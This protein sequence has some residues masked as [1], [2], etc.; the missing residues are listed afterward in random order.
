MNK[1]KAGI[2]GATGYAGLEIARLLLSHPSVE[3]AAV[4]SVSF[5]GKL[6]SDVYPAMAQVLDKELETGEAVIAAS[7]VAFASLPH[8]LSEKYAK[9]CMDKGSVFID[10]GA[11]FRLHNPADYEKWYGGRYGDLPL[12]EAAVYGL[13]E[14]FR[15]E[16]KG[17]KLIANPGCYPTS[18]ALGLY[19]ALKMG[20]VDEG[21]IIIDAK[22]G[23]TGAGRGLSQ[24]THYPDTNEAFA[25]YKV[26]D[27]RHTPEIEQTLSAISGKSVFVTFVPHLLPVNRGII[28]TIYAALAPGASFEDVRAQYRRT[29]G[30]EPFVRVMKDG[31]TANLRNVRMSN[32]CDISLHYDARVSRLIVVSAIDNM[33]KGAAG[34]AIQNMNIAFG[35][36]ETQGLAM[37]PP[38]F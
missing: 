13:P 26:A 7:D 5:E 25:P 6:L 27:H 32:Y 21:T 36:D 37:V 22:S 9:A 29:Y 35:L 20:A 31:E 17:K 23:V 18:I 34:Q 30:S 2:I 33:V 8:G 19:P 15:E 16:I 14:I 12:H 1:I 11:D 3:I 38:A 4:S 24:S 28:S 10:M